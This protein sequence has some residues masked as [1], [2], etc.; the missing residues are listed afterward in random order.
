M[1]VS[2]GTK[3]GDVKMKRKTVVFVIEHFTVAR[4]FF[5]RQVSGFI[6]LTVK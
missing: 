5:Q 3:A 1:V 2:D 4:H 6:T